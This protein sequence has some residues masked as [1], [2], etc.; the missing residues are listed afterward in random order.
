[1]PNLTSIFQLLNCNIYLCLLIF[2]ITFILLV[3]KE[4]SFLNCFDIHVFHTKCSFNFISTLGIKSVKRMKLWSQ[5]S[6]FLYIYLK[7]FWFV[8]LLPE[9]IFHILC[10]LPIS[11]DTIFEQ[12]CFKFAFTKILVHFSIHSF[13]VDFQ[14]GLVSYGM[15][16][17]LIVIK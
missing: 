3:R 13:Q 12:K 2:Y 8:C 7:W 4:R 15:I 5:F 1:M 6:L 9:R 17:S 11:L 14:F 10:F 16:W